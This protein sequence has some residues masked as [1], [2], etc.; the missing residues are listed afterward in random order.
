MKHVYE[1]HRKRAENHGDFLI[2]VFK[3]RCQVRTAVRTVELRYCAW[4]Y[5]G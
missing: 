5:C 2:T 3:Y 1:R 4:K